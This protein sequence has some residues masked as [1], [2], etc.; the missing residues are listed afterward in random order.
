MRVAFSV[1][2][3]GVLGCSACL[4]AGEPTGP[5]PYGIA[6]YISSTN[7]QNFGFPAGM[8]TYDWNNL[9]TDLAYQMVRPFHYWYRYFVPGGDYV[10]DWVTYDVQNQPS[11]WFTQESYPTSAPWNVRR[12]CNMM[13]NRYWGYYL[14]RTGG[15]HVGQIGLPAAM[16][17]QWYVDQGGDHQARFDAWVTSNPGRIWLM[18]NEPGGFEQ[19]ADLMGQDALT[20][21]E[22]AVFY[23]TYTSYIAARD[24]NARFANAAMAMTT[25]PTWA[26]H[27]TVESVIAIWERILGIC[28]TEYGQDMPVDIWNIHLYAGHGCQDPAVHRSEYVSV[29]EDFR[30]FV[31]TT[32]GG[33]YQ[34]SPLILTEFNGTYDASGFTQTNVV[35]FLH[36]FR[37]DLN[38]LWIRGV[39]DEWFWFVSNGGTGWPAVSILEAGGLSIVGEEYRAAAWHWEALKPPIDERYGTLGRPFHSPN[40]GLWNLRAA[41]DG[42]AGNGLTVNE[43][44]PNHVT[45]TV[46]PGSATPGE[47]TLADDEHLTGLDT[48][49]FLPGQGVGIEFSFAADDA[50]NIDLYIG[51]LHGEGGPD[52]GESGVILRAEAGDASDT[53][54]LDACTGDV[55][56]TQVDF[57]VAHKIFF[58]ANGD[59]EIALYFDDVA[60]P[61]QTLS[62]QSLPDCDANRLRFG[63][64]SAKV[65]SGASFKGAVDVFAY[66]VDDDILHADFAKLRSDYDKDG[67]VDQADYGHLQPCLSGAG[68]PQTAIECR[69]VY[70]DN[71][72]DVDQDDVDIF[73]GCM[74]GANVAA[75]VTCQQ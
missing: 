8:N 15:N 20:D 37:D 45:V 35:A 40:G 57:R 19:V 2:I 32:R 58:V 5:N 62:R 69:D 29:I 73:L 10:Q 49:S 9:R 50:L 59:R 41:G 66:A 1:F 7:L 11:E 64:N 24:P 36:D 74:S 42:A 13:L 28:A 14:D 44:Q 17:P 61:L 22:Y 21:L 56:A 6:G 31:D 60:V 54:V 55:L 3:C 72:D 39:L 27:L 52:D 26:E 4:G 71:D 47:I 67:D 53:T 51:Y 33:I 75:D 70:L 34:D 23:H 48:F 38:T 63:S 18:G 30:A 46:D 12:G 25:S 43:N 16:L 65:F 68:V